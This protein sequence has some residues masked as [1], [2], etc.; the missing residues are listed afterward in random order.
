MVGKI[1]IF[2]QTYC[3]MEPPAAL[4]SERYNNP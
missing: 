3:I 4:I 2:M 1:Q